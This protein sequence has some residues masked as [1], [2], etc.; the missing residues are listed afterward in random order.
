MC[1]FLFIEREASD[2]Q[3][4]TKKPFESTTR[5]S[6]RRFRSSSVN[7]KVEEKEPQQH[8]THKTTFGSEVKQMFKKNKGKPAE[9]DALGESHQT[10]ICTYK[11]K[12]I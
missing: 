11:Y 6:F 12:L 10:C 2:S 4:F 9:E 7:N 8:S 1:L 5:S 3:L